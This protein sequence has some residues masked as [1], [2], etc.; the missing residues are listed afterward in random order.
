MKQ[1]AGFWASSWKKMHEVTNV[2]INMGRKYGQLVQLMSSGYKSPFTIGITNKW[3]EMSTGFA[4]KWSPIREK[5]NQI[6]V[7]WPKQ[8][9]A[10][11]TD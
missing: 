9:L 8:K 5:N 7:W 3:I 2:K 1:Y 10:K 4:T 6:Q 11:K